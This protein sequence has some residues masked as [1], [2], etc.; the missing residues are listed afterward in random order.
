MLKPLTLLFYMVGLLGVVSGFYNG[1]PTL[2]KVKKMV[3]E[4]I[5]DLRYSVTSLGR[6]RYWKP[7]PDFST[8]KEIVKYRN[9]IKREGF[10]HIIQGGGADITKLA[11]V[12]LRKRNP[13]GDKFKMVLQVHDEILAE[14][15]E[16]IREGATHF[17]ESIMREVEQPFLGDIP[18]ACESHCAKEWSK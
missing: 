16:D 2:T 17:M 8:P 12:E 18:A 5:I 10:N 11:I 9:R 3:E 14:I 6:K 13:F 4:K 1:Y 15:T 7:E